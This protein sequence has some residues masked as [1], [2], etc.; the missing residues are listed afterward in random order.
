MFDFLIILIA[1]LIVVYSLDIYLTHKLNKL[2]REFNDLLLEQNRL[3][4]RI[5]FGEPEK[6][7]MED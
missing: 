7:K 3:L 2:K 5:V 1:I 6:G 4:K